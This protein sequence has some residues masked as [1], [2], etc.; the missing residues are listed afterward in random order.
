MERG[1][2]TYPVEQVQIFMI[3]AFLASEGGWHSS[4]NSNQ[5]EQRPAFKS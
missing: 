3:Y 4:H 1:L 5:G 2:A